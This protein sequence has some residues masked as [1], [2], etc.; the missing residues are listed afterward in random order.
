M[1]EIGDVVF[2]KDAECNYFIGIVVNIDD[3][4]VH[5]FYSRKYCPLSKI[6][7]SCTIKIKNRKIIHRYKLIAS[8]NSI[9]DDRK[10]SYTSFY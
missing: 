3:I 2:F 5:V 4:G 6:N 8:R 10:T 1:F 9:K 7:M